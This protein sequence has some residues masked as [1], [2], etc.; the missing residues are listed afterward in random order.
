MTR[1]H[2]KKQKEEVPSGSAALGR[3]RVKVKAQRASL[4]EGPGRRVGLRRR[5]RVMSVGRVH[6]RNH[7]AVQHG[8]RTTRDLDKE[9]LVQKYIL[10]NKSASALREVVHTS[11]EANIDATRNLVSGLKYALAVAGASSRRREVVHTTICDGDE[12]VQAAG[13]ERLFTLRS[14]MAIATGEAERLNER[15]R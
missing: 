3:R 12:R 7:A 2:R 1:K 5:R 15:L 8:C 9:G 6:D 14:A 10:A 4:S 13:T 11:S